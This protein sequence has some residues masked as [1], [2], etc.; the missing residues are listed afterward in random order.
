MQNTKL[1]SYYKILSKRLSI[2]Y[3]FRNEITLRDRHGG[4]GGLEVRGRHRKMNSTGLD[5]P[6]PLW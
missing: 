4:G 6:L 2:Y 5:L 3:K 1:N